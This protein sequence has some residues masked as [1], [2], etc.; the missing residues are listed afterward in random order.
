MFRLRFFKWQVQSITSI[1]AIFILTCSGCEEYTRN[2][3]DVIVLKQEV[4]DIQLVISELTM[5]INSVKTDLRDLKQNVNAGNINLTDGVES[6]LD[7]INDQIDLIG[8]GI[9]QIQDNPIPSSDNGNTDTSESIEDTEEKVEDIEET[10]L[11]MCQSLYGRSDTFVADEVITIDDKRIFYNYG[12]EVSSAEGSNAIINIREDGTF[13]L[14]VFFSLSCQT[15]IFLEGD[16]PISD[17]SD[18]L[19]ETT[20]IFEYRLEDEDIYFAF[21]KRSDGTY[22]LITT[23]PTESEQNDVQTITENTEQSNVIED[24]SIIDVATGLTICQVDDVL[25]INENCIYRRYEDGTSIKLNVNQD[26]VPSLLFFFADSNQELVISATSETDDDNDENTKVFQ[27]TD[28]FG[29]QLLTELVVLGLSKIAINIDG[30]Y[31]YRL[32]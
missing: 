24:T 23:V 12:G 10:I 1:V 31:I 5:A 14:R 22:Q 30:D 20:Y 25:S 19:G 21:K 17:T 16:D 3:D 18:N 28:A 9:N 2:M 13:E 7:D 8:E 15:F 29:H 32:F 4:D 6:H 11:D 26:I 27:A